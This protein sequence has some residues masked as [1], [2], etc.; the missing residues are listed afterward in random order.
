MNA[1]ETTGPNAR[2]ESIRR[3]TD[4]RLILY[5]EGALKEAYGETAREVLAEVARRLD[6]RASLVP[7][8]GQRS[9]L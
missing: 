7:Q 9:W 1:A 4:D 3:S 6:E 8:N 2:L 5:L